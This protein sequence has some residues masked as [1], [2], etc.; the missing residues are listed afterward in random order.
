MRCAFTAISLLACA[1]CTDFDTP[2]ELPRDA[3]LAVRST[4]AAIAPGGRGHLDALL[5]GPEG[6]IDDAELRWSVVGGRGAIE[7][8]DHGE[9]WLAIPAGATEGGLQVSLVATTANAELAAV[10]QVMIADPARDNP[11]MIRLDAAGAAIGEQTLRCQTGDI[12]SLAAELDQPA[13]QHISWF[14]T[15]GV[16]ELYRHN[17]TELVAPDEPETGW[18]IAVGRDGLG[19]V[20]WREIAVEIE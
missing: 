14:S 13:T 8:D 11:L 7:T 20:T 9:V 19:G 1:G 5:A 3:I 10:K 2:S 15:T 12:V 4:P 16:I 17:P 18:L 6:P